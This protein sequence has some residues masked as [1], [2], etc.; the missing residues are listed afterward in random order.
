MMPRHK[1]FHIVFF[2]VAINFL[3]G[4]PTAYAFTEN[5]AK[6]SCSAC[7]QVELK[8]KYCQS[9][10]KLDIN[11]SAILHSS[12]TSFLAPASDHLLIWAAHHQGA[13]RAPFTTSMRLNL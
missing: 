4:C 8:K 5:K 13:N 1:I 7:S 2:I 9:H 3:F 10:F 11:P 12:Q 6:L